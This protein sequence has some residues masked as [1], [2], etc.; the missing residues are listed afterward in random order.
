MCHSLFQALEAGDQAIQAGDREN[1]E[2]FWAG[3]HQKDLFAFISR[4]AK[5][6]F[7]PRQ[8]SIA[9]RVGAAKASAGQD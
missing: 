5:L 4:C 6:R 3:N 2:N 9:K 8:A 1:A 7:W